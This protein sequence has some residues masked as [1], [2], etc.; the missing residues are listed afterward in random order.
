MR[1]MMRTAFSGLR[2]AAVL[3]LLV[4]SGAAT[5]GGA[6]AG[7]ATPGGADFGGV[8]QMAEYA[9]TVRAELNDPKF[10]DKA[11]RWQEEFR[12]DRDPTVDDP[13]KS[14]I[15]KG[16]PWTMTSRARDYP[17]EI[18]QTGD[19]IIMIFEGS[20]TTRVIY[21][22][23]EDFPEVGPS[24]NGFS[25]GKWD[26]DTLVIRTKGLLATAFPNPYMR[27]EQAEVIERWSLRQD[28]KHG[29]VIDID[30]TVID[31]EIYLEP[32]KGR[33]VWK[34]APAGTAAGGYNCTQALWDEYIRERQRLILK[35]EAP[36]VDAR[37]P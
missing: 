11:R 29:E 35:G 31:P 19:R 24:S 1:D 37:L 27:S 28:A 32:A 33:Q 13:N 18:Y 25:I 23:R 6:A 3:S 15:V 8:W 34:R 10:T 22:D 2:R 20:D 4:V 21:L 9:Y 16:M 14:C 17:T 12:R 5:A 26:G 36:G 7:G 30:V